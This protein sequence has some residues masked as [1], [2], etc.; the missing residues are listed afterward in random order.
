PTRRIVRAGRYSLKVRGGAELPGRDNSRKGTQQLDPILYNERGWCCTPSFVCRRPTMRRG[1]FLTLGLLELAVGAVLV[2][3]S[4][5]LPT[6][7][8][9]PQSFGG[10]QRVS[11]HTSHEVRLLRD[12]VHEL[13]HPEIHQLAGRRH[14][15]VRQLPG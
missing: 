1:L 4:F 10:L 14:P 8:D 13:R 3:F 5:Q 15:H 7:A 6:T 12:Q 2:V 9:V 11:A